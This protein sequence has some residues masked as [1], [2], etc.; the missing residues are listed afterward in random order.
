MFAKANLPALRRLTH[1]SNVGPVAICEASPASSPLR[2]ARLTSARSLAPL[3]ATLELL[4]Q[5]HGKN[6][7]V[8]ALWSPGGRLVVAQDSF[9]QLI[10]QVLLCCP[11][12][13]CVRPLHP[14]SCAKQI[15]GD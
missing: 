5:A 12:L 11:R 6:L 3:P 14:S 7:E 13:R 2:V 8:L 9:D 4:C 1:W 15:A 10:K